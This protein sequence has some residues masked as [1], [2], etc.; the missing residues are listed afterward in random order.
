MI[1]ICSVLVI[2]CTDD[3]Q[4]SNPPALKDAPHFT[5][6][7]GEETI[8]GGESTSFTIKIIDAPGGISDSIVFTTPDDLGDFVFS[9]LASVLGQ[10]SGDITGT[11]TAPTSFDGD[12]TIEVTV[13]DQQ[14]A[15]LGQTAPKSL[16]NTAKIKI[17][18]PGDAPDF[19]V[20]LGA[21][22]VLRGESVS[23]DVSLDVAGG[24][25]N[26]IIL[27]NKGTVEIDET[28]LT[29]AAGQATGV[30][31][32]TYTADPVFSGEVT[33]SVSITDQLQNRTTTKESILSADYAFDAPS[34]DG[35]FTKDEFTIFEETDMSASI[36]APGVIKSISVMAYTK[37]SYGAYDPDDE[38]SKLVEVGTLKLGEGELDAAIGLT[39]ANITGTFTSLDYGYVVIEVIVIDEEGRETIEVSEVL[40]KNAEA[41]SYTG[42]Y[43]ITASGNTGGGAPYAADEIT[44]GVV[45]SQVGADVLQFDDMSFGLY[46]DVYGDTAP[47]GRVTISDCE[48]GG[49][50]TDM[51]DLDQYDDPFTIN[52]TLNAD[53]SISLT[54]SNTYGDNGVVTLTPVQ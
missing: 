1:A 47:K 24:F 46:P 38:N 32:A 14:E 27:P 8:V 50:L 45:I 19:T 28:S 18:Y 49:T 22:S 6:T 10:T 13:F 3:F 34:I 5:F 21:A 33:I 43:T 29:A 26:I 20:A 4:D 16:S 30:I 40:V 25:K 15:G 53:G 41:C 48:D 11:F 42:S 52:G 2:S 17:S 9:N 12:F 35:S 44:S 31:K 23:I 7:L 36:T 51:G 37:D 39:T 54:W